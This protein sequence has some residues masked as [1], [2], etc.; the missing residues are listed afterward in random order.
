MHVTP[1]LNATEVLGFTYKIS[2]SKRVY[3]A[4][5]LLSI[6]HVIATSTVTFSENSNKQ[7]V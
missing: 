5:S 2:I 6:M 4:I 7:I 3:S 1:T